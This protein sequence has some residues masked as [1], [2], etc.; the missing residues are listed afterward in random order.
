MF[1]CCYFRQ[2]WNRHRNEFETKS[3]TPT[4]TRNNTSASSDYYIYP[5]TYTHTH[6]HQY[7]LI[8]DALEFTW[9]WTRKVIGVQAHACPKRMN[10]SRTKK[11]ETDLWTKRRTDAL[12][13]LESWNYSIKVST[14]AECKVSRWN[15][16]RMCIRKSTT[17][18]KV[19]HF[20]GFCVSWNCSLCDAENRPVRLCVFLLLSSFFL[21]N[22][23]LSFFTMM[24]LVEVQMIVF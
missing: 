1:T 8:E 15:T 2:I 7:R 19:K 21:E 24:Q 11:G 10:D 22:E 5:K 18:K 12:D 6:T 16:F 9:T 17:H 14:Y 20:V 3:K 13:D 23:F 4:N